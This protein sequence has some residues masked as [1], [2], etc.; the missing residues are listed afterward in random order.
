MAKHN[1]YSEGNWNVVD[2][3]IRAW[4]WRTFEYADA[5]TGEVQQGRA[6]RLTIER[7]KTNG[8]FLFHVDVPEAIGMDFIEK[9]EE[10]DESWTFLFT[11]GQRRVTERKLQTVVK[12]I[13][14]DDGIDE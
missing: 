8:T 14:W 11:G 12:S 3:P 7:P 4:E 1:L 9:A 2:A 6:L 10:A 5:T 13:D